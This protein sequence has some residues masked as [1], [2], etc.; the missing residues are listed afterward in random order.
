VEVLESE[1]DARRSAVEK[2]KDQHEL[3]K[4]DQAE[5]EAVSH[6]L[7]GGAPVVLTSDDAELRA[8]QK[9]GDRS[10]GNVAEGR[11]AIWGLRGRQ[12]TLRRRR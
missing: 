12:A 8:G 4:L 9:D 11:D 5:I 1:I 3:L 2:L 10:P 7:Q 6:L